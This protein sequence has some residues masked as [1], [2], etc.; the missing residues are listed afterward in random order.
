MN[1][2]VN[3]KG[4]IRQIVARVTCAV[5]GHHF[6]AGDIQVLGHREQIWAMQ[7]TCRE[8][9]TQAL[10]LAVV[11]GKGARP[12]HTDLSPDEWQRVKDRPP[13]SVDDVI[14]LHQYLQAYDG[15]FSEILEEP[16]PDED[17]E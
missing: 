17:E 8:C 10:L 2:H 11:D 1:E 9:R 5:C 3:D 4:L 12:V 6:A 13:V 14:A 16:L 7:I 15:D